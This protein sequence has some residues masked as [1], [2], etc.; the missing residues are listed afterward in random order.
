MEVGARQ[1]KNPKIKKC[2]CVRSVLLVAF[3]C[4]CVCDQ[5]RFLDEQKRRVAI[6]RARKEG[7][8]QTGS[9]RKEYACESGWEVGKRKE[10]PKMRQKCTKESEINCKFGECVCV[11]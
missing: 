9:E 4:V 3:C 8:E 5:G 1:G 11:L 6:W 2:K 7:E 10:K